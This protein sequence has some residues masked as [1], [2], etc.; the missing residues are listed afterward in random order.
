MRC[1]RARAPHPIGRYVWPNDRRRQRCSSSTAA[2]RRAWRHP[3][4]GA[5]NLPGL[6][7]LP[8]SRARWPVRCAG[9]PGCACSASATRTGA[10]TA[11]ARTRC[12]T[13][14]GCWTTCGARRA[15]SPWS[16]SAT[17]WAP[18][19]HCT[20]AGHPLVRSVVGLA[21]WCPPGDPVT[22]LAGR[23]VVLLHSTRDRV[24]SPLASQSLTARARRAGARTCLVTIPGSDHAMIR[25]APA[26]H[27]LARP[28]GDGAAG[29][30]PR[31]RT[32]SRR[33]S[34][35]PRG[36]P[37]RRGRCPWTDST[38]V[39]P[40][41]RRCGAAAG[42]RTMRGRVL[43]RPV[44]AGP[45]RTAGHRPLWRLRCRPKSTPIRP[46]PT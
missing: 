4:P 21:P 23:D 40:G 10:G 29:A 46:T 25:R 18:A 6:R 24:T 28:A 34:G 3:P 9:T 8:V 22:Q 14:Y 37:R 5:L 44:R 19:P 32:G 20:R 31:S 13:P 27:H 2:T 16:S 7:M 39:G 42:R 17:P 41:P 45:P 1:G 38:P 36:Q 12:T 26:W 33:R 15:T 35:C 43:G 30:D 11:P